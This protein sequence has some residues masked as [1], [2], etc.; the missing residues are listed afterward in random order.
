MHEPVSRQPSRLTLALSGG[1]AILAAALLLTPHLAGF[2]MW[3]DEINMVRAGLAFNPFDLST[4]T[5]RSGHPPLYF[6]LLKGWALLA[7]TSDFS[8]RLLS[9]LPA[10]VTAAF[11][12][13]IAVDMTGKPSAGFI[14]ALVFASMGF[15]LYYVHETHNYG[16]LMMRAVDL[17]FF[18]ER[19]R[20]FP[21]NRAYAIGA[22]ISTTVLMLT[23][24]YAAFFIGA[25]NLFALADAFR[26][27]RGWLQWVRLQVVAAVLYLPWMGVIVNLALRVAAR[28]AGGNTRVFTAQTTKW[29][30]IEEMFRV[31]LSEQA[32]VYGLVIGI[33]II[34]LMWLYRRKQEQAREMLRGAALLATLIIG[35]VALALLAN[36]FYRTFTP[37]RV[38]YA[39]PTL[40]ILIGLLLATLPR[41]LKWSAAAVAVSAALAAGW[42]PIQPGDWM[43]R[44]AVEAV[45]QDY[46]PGDLVFIQMREDQVFFERPLVYYTH[47]ILRPGAAILTA[48]Q[49]ALDDPPTQVDF[50]SR[51]FADQVWTRDRFWVISA[52][53]PAQGAVSLDWVKQI[54]GRP[55]TLKQ[56]GEVGLIR[57]SLF[58]ADTAARGAMPSAANLGGGPPLA[59]V[60]GDLIELDR[61]QVD[62]ATVRP[63]ETITLWL[64]WQA[65]RP[66]ERSYSIYVHLLAEDGTLIAQGDGGPTHL[67]REIDT[68]FWAPLMRVYDVKTVTLPADALPGRY[69]LRIGVYDPIEGTRLPPVPGDGTILDGLIV[70]SIEIR[71]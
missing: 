61:V 65:I 67:G 17:L 7:G 44:Q 1:L 19:W 13:R 30:T 26:N 6:V 18:Y 24:Y 43:F 59:Q 14:A 31:M 40:A 47:Q 41:W 63:G 34:G 56:S 46:R 45:A 37:R 49:F 52:A 2:S 62:S 29:K 54:P 53:D 20:A 16:L 25:L 27:W 28:K 4:Y 48:G 32:L 71:P 11:L 39:L 23:H 42:S 15:V 9:L 21:R 10:L 36:I 69:Q 5:L 35:S 64:D 8:L 57:L 51:V 60:F 22:V 50:A 58:E 33:G 55:F 68:I 3:S 12:F 70:A 38:I 66:V